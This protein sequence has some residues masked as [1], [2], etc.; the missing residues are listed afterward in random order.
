[1]RRLPL[2]IMDEQ[3]GV[4]DDERWLDAAE[5]SKNSE[6]SEKWEES[7]RFRESPRLEVVLGRSGVPAVELELSACE[8]DGVPITRR[9]SGGGTVLLGPGCLV[10]AMI[11]ERSRRSQWDC[12]ETIHRNVLE[13][14][15]TVLTP[16]A[17][18][19]GWTVERAGVCDLVL[20][21]D[22]E[23]ENEREN[24][25]ENNGRND[26]GNGGESDG[27]H[28]ERISSSSQQS[29]SQTPQNPS[30]TL[31]TQTFRKFSGNAVRLRRRTILYHGTILYDFPLTLMSRYLQ[32]PPRQ[33]VYRNGRSHMEFVVNFPAPRDA[34]LDAIAQAF[35]V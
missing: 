28:M 30:L 10:Y 9:S 33:P 27:D 22:V 18:M 17:T 2:T 19:N 31:R 23:R 7:I 20:R 34:I 16:L 6:K 25:G 14:M 29:P 15:I 8:Q 35:D 13:R 1:M 3:T 11:L 5:K 21:P 26:F 24:N 4:A 32:S 12:I